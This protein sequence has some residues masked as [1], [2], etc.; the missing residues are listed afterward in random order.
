MGS[1]YD[2][3]T[4]KKDFIRGKDYSKWF[5][6]GGKPT[7]GLGVGNKNRKDKKK[8]IKTN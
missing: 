5:K 4:T 1:G 3:R 6:E 2:S 8:T 7:F